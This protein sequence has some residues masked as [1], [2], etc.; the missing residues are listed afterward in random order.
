MAFP[1]LSI[2]M[3]RIAGSKRVAFDIL[4]LLK[5]AVVYIILIVYL[6]NNI[7]YLQQIIFISTIVHHIMKN[8]IKIIFFFY[9]ITSIN[10]SNAQSPVLHKYNNPNIYEV[11]NAYY[12]D[13]DKIQDP[14]VGTWLY[15]NGNTSLKI[16]FI[17]RVM[18]KTTGLKKNHYADY[19]VGEYQY[20]ENGI[21]KV[22]TLAT[23]NSNYTDVG[24]Y[25]LRSISQK[26]KNTYPKCPE[27][28]ENEKRLN[29][30]LNEPTRR[31][32]EGMDNDFVI[33][34]YTENG[35]IKLKVWFVKTDNDGYLT[36]EGNPTEITGYSLP[37]GQY[38]LTKQP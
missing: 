7:R 21:E 26:F 12:K 19:L 9:C 1:I 24:K 10:N 16:I 32:I 6:K 34:R 20:I 25:N 38:I 5:L 15:T 28:D 4:Q 35:I 2:Y 37:Y 27:C 8:A 22:N 17:N 14:Y 29:M 23:I 30:L 36:S 18:A 13:I 33:R 3:M 11:A 31:N